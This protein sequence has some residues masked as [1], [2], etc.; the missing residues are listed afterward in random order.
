MC[1]LLFT[2]HILLPYLILCRMNDT[3]TTKM[4]MFAYSHLI[5]MNMN[6]SFVFYS[7]MRNAFMYFIFLTIFPRKIHNVRALEYWKLISRRT[8]DFHVGIVH[9]I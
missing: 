8:D 9:K 5:K 7:V 3:I 4:R 6:Y 2:L 1:R